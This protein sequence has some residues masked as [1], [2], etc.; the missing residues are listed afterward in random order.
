[1]V[2]VI[3]YA[4]RHYNVTQPWNNGFAGLDNFRQMLFHDPVF[5]HSL[6]FSLSWVA[7]QVGLQLLL[8]L[9][10]ALIVNETFVGR[11]VARSLVFSPWAV[12]GVL[13]TGIWLLIYN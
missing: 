6:R 10:L 8:G 13:T 3:Y 4:L 12:S 5:W 2:S 7:A 9:G 1:M 11:G